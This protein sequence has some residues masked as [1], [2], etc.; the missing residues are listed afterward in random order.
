[1]PKFIKG[2]PVLNAKMNL[3]PIESKYLTFIYRK[4]I[5][6]KERV[7]TTILARAFQVNPATV[8]ET[9]Q[10]LAS[11]KLI[12]YTRYYGLKLTENG[13]TKAEKLL[14]KHRILELLFVKFLKYN[15][16]KA[17]EEASKI[18]YYCSEDLINAICR[19]YGHPDTCPCDKKIFKDSTCTG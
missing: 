18:D 15:A 8:T 19:T 10:R 5:E 1:L 7:T 2:E 12:E 9:L 16:E 6:E 13:T 4:Q 17:C 3:T 11:K 14:R